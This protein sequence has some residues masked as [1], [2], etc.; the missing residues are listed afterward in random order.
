M[1]FK[2]IANYFLGYGFLGITICL[3][4]QVPLLLKL[5]S[6]HS[7]KVCQDLTLAGQVGMRS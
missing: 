7:L 3:L 4:V 6:L 1:Y 2:I 5:S